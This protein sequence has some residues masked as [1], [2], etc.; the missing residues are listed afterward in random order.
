MPFKIFYNLA[1]TTF[2]IPEHPSPAN[3]LWKPWVS[4]VELTPVSASGSGYRDEEE[5]SFIL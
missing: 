5:I 2:Q 4:Q 3:H 1:P